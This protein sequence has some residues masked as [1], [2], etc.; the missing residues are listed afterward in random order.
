MERWLKELRLFKP[1][2]RYLDPGSVMPMRARWVVLGIMWT[3]VMGSGVVFYSRG[4]LPWAAAPL[5]LAG[6]MATVAI[7]RFRRGR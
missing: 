4:L 2:T 6:L 3:A 7:W 5:G 1:Y